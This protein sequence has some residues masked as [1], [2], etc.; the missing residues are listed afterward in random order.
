MPGTLHTPKKLP[1]ALLDGLFDYAGLF[2]PASLSMPAAVAEYLR[3]LQGAEARLVGPFVVPVGKL[4]EAEQTFSDASASLTVLPRAGTAVL[5]LLETLREDLDACFRLSERTSGRLQTRAIELPFPEEAF[6]DS[7]VSSQWMTGL[8]TIVKASNLPI[9]SAYLEL[10][11]TPAYHDRLDPYFVALRQ[12]VGRG[13]P[14]RGKLRFG[15]GTPEAYPSPAQVASFIDA[16]CRHGHPFKATAGLHHPFRHQTDRA[17]IIMHGF[18]NVFVGA[19]MHR[20]HGLPETDLVELIDERDPGAFVVRETG[21]AWRSWH[22]SADALART[23]HEL[24]IGIGSCSIQEP[25]DDL[26]H[27]HLLNFPNP[28]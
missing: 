27:F 14:V 23:R 1:F 13:V 28:T 19:A 15:G 7:H 5:P 18:M 8:Q 10:V 16:A 25:L 3:H 21:I 11:R 6:N 20:E 12:S 9:A 2:P 4:D 24:A 22:V 26:A 17:D